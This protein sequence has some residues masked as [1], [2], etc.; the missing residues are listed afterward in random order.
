MTIAVTHSNGDIFQHFGKS[1]QFKL[2]E[3][4]D[5]KIVSSEIVD[6]DG[7]GHEALSG[8]LKNLGVDILI[9]GG[10]GQCAKN[11]MSEAK[12]NVYCGVSGSCDAAVNDL[13]SDKLNYNLEST[14]SHHGHE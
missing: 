5:D 13:L 6:T 4:T 12:I 11:A 8:F 10:I 9:C 14:C 1:D 3:L 7:S 2:Y